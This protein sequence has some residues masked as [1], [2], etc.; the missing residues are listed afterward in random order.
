MFE[1]IMD[2][3]I[4]PILDFFSRWHDSG[5]WHYSHLFPV[6]TIAFAGIWWL[7][8]YLGSGLLLVFG[9]LGTVGFGIANLVTW[10]PREVGA[11]R[12]TWDYIARKKREARGK[13][14]Q[15]AATRNSRM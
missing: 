7:G 15:E 13:E 5:K 10:I 12:D 4:G 6:A 11:W 9:V 1:L 2:W 3:V 14:E 8:E